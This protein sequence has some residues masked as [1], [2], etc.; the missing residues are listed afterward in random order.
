MKNYLLLTVK[1]GKGKYQVVLGKLI[2]RTW[3]LYYIY[4][5]VELY[6]FLSVWKLH[7]RRGARISYMLGVPVGSGRPTLVLLQQIVGWGNLVPLDHL[8]FARNDAWANLVVV[9]VIRFV[10]AL[11]WPYLAII[12][13]GRA[14][15]IQ[16]YRYAARLLITVLQMTLPPWTPI[17][18]YFIILSIIIIL[19]G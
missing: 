12:S 5:V 10:V 11:G 17:I 4:E 16:F 15:T 3:V 1:H 8:V 18:I 6:R 13:C 14:N 2:I 7:H 19:S 9:L